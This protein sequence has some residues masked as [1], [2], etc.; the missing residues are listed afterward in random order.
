MKFFKAILKAA[1]CV[2]VRRNFTEL[3][4]SERC[5]SVFQCFFY[6]I[7]KVQKRVNLVDLRQEL[8]SEHLLAKFGFDTAEDEPSKVCQELDR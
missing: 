1:R 2:N 7:P 3:L 5:K 8:S 4:N 6:W